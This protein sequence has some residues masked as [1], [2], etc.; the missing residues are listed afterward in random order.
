M[1]P[2]DKPLERYTL[3]VS[4]FPHNVAESQRT[5]PVQDLGLTWGDLKQEYRSLIV[6]FGSLA[7][8][9]REG[10]KPESRGESDDEEEDDESTEVISTF[11]NLPADCSFT[12][13]IEVPPTQAI[14]SSVG[15]RLCVVDSALT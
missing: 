1:D 5:L 2:E 10:G 3:D 8:N 15:T 12:A 11:G 14:E 7:R 9:G 13:T 4:G 6:Y